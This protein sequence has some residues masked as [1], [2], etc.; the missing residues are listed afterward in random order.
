MAGAILCVSCAQL[1]RKDKSLAS[2]TMRCPE[3]HA[4]FGVT[5]YGTAFRFCRRQ[6][7]A[8]LGGRCDRDHRRRGRV[9]FVLLLVG[10]GIWSA[11]VAVPK[12]AA[13]VASKPAHEFARVPEV[14]ID[15][16]LAQ[17]NPAAAKTAIAA[18]RRQDSRG[19]Q[20]RQ[21]Q[22]CVRACPDGTASRTARPAI[23]DGRRVP[24]PTAKATSFENSVQ[25]VRDGME[26]DFHR[27]ASTQD[28]T[29]GFWNGYQSRVGGNGVQTEHGVAALAQ[30]LGP[31]RM[32]LRHSMVRQ[33]AQSNTSDA[34]RVLAKA[35]IFDPA[36]EVRQTAIKELKKRPKAH[37]FDDILM[38]GVRHPMAVVSHRAAYAIGQ[39]ERNDLAP[40]LAAFLDEPA[41][42][43][44]EKK[45]VDD[46]EVCEVREVVRINHHR[47]CLLCHPPSATGQPN[48]V[49]GVIPI[50]GNS[51]APSPKEA[52]GRAQSI[53]DPMVRADTTY[54]RQDFSMMMPVANHGAWPDMQRF[55]FIVRNRAVD[56][57][58]LKVMQEKIKARPAGFVAEQHRAA[59]DALRRI[60]GQDA[61]P[62]GAAW[63][64]AIRVNRNNE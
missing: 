29:L 21:G 46:K 47:N 56:A 27:S 58:E 31:E 50:P 22:G 15:D 41:P 2:K 20:Q 4:A 49:P 32:A 35:A 14:A 8:V 13:V 54:L 45:V 26:R 59:T 38:H 16:P 11:D 48:E 57:N 6:K 52:Y 19:K 36:S 42:G 39:L 23:R 28:D 61:G 25:A 34:T 51:F 40:Q 5:S 53:G 18:A 62:N 12:R 33:L 55:D 43:D 17:N 7:P 63:L 37:K 60:T 30:I 3:C 44:P 9:H 1:P 10:M 24:A 64:N